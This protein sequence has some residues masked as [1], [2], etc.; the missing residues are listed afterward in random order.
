MKLFACFFLV[1]PWFVHAHDPAPCRRN[2][3]RQIPIHDYQFTVHSSFPLDELND[4]ITHVIVV[5][6][7]AERQADV[8]YAVMANLVRKQGLQ[9]NTL[10]ISPSFKTRK[11]SPAETEPFW[12]DNGWKEGDDSKSLPY[13]LS[14]FAVVDEIISRILGQQLFNNVTRVTV[15]G[16]S[17]GG[18]FTQMYA[19]TSPIADRFPLI[20]FQYIVMNPSSYVYLTD[21]RFDKFSDSFRAPIFASEEHKTEFSCVNY[22]NYKFGLDNRPV[23]S[24]IESNDT[25]VNRYLRRDVTYAL[26]SA[27][28]DSGDRM[29]NTSCAANLQGANRFERGQT[30]LRHLTALDRNHAHHLIVVKDIGHDCKGMYNSDGVKSALFPSLSGQSHAQA[31]INPSPPLKPLTQESFPGK[32]SK[33]MRVN[34][35]APTK[36]P[37]HEKKHG[38]FDLPK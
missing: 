36:N 38:G 16:H 30:F 23:Y 29:L 18:Q 27:D 15:T 33:L 28:N 26:G 37:T 24:K 12:S 14:S 17:A 25:L 8:R 3:E 19:L 6:Q 21:E 7:G 10:V 5:V 34:K 22:N 11:D 1:L 4:A 32:S 2:C 35:G 9:K 31:K 20:A 13:A